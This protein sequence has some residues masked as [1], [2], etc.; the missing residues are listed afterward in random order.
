MNPATIK[1]SVREFAQPQQRRGHIDMF[2]GYAK[3]MQ[4]GTEIHSIIQAR[5]I[6]AIPNYQQEYSLGLEITK[7]DTAFNISGRCDGVII[8]DSETIIEEIKTTSNIQRLIETLKEIPDHPYIL[9]AKTYGFIY[10]KTTDITPK[11][12]LRLVSSIGLKEN[13][14]EV[15]FDI[16]EYEKWFFTRL[17]ILKNQIIGQYKSNERRKELAKNLKFPFPSNRSSQQDLI[18][19]I[20]NWLANPTHGLIQA[21]TG[22]GKTAG[23]MY[24]TLKNSLAKGAQLI[25]VTPK[26]SQH[27]LAKET[28]EKFQ[29]NNQPVRS[30]TI[31][32]KSKSCMLE[33]PLCSPDHCPYAKNY[34][35]KVSEHKIK[36]KMKSYPTLDLDD[37]KSLAE[38]Y[39]VCPF[40]LSLEAARD[41][42][43]VICDYNY[44]FSP[45][46]S[47]TDLYL[48]ENGESLGANLVIDEAHNLPSRATDYFSPELQTSFIEPLRE[49]LDLIPVDMQKKWKSIVNDALTCIKNQDP[50]N[51]QPRSLI[52][53]DTEGFIS[54]DTRIA[55]FTMQ[56]FD[57]ISEL[58]SNDPVIFLQRYW[59]D[60]CFSLGL[61]GEHSFATFRHL[62]NSKSV[63]ITCC[64]ASDHLRERLK[65]FSNVIAFSATLKPFEYYAQLSGF[66]DGKF[67]TAEFQSPF[68]KENRKILVIPQV[69]TLY[70]DREKNYPKIGEAINKLVSIKQGNYFVFFS[71][72]DFMEQTL[73]FINAQGYRLYKQERNIG[74]DEAQEVI[75]AL[76]G[77]SK[78][79]LVLAVQGGVFAEGVDYPGDTLIGA[80]VVG[81]ALPGFDFERE[82]LRQYYDQ[83]YT[84][85]FEYAYVYPGM[86]K[87]IQSAGRVIRSETDKGIIILL[88]ARFQNSQYT[89]VMPGFWFKDSVNE[90]ISNQ[91]TKDLEDFW[92]DQK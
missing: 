7:D 19:M 68:P 83:K 70:R 61:G 88:G 48:D 58:K 90:L 64:D 14:Y 91:I 72:F 26:N 29:E 85:G 31:N 47:F 23:V 1:I 12:Q 17:S 35:D 28:V 89:N 53:L 45:R 33:E 10:F 77:G 27:I 24:P 79:V 44:I 16:D 62:K 73:P 40:E 36:D 82:Q 60:F 9:Q 39:E 69:S 71:S 3:Q 67:T 18:N 25:Y 54:I 75:N 66:S 80:I 4:L 43:V 86:A 34:Y 52:S 20:D 38:T 55:A 46:I 6:K 50:N 87:V 59:G 42:D 32:A 30:L 81:P 57:Q 21:P 76:K 92:N 78:K 63:K 5:S 13:T 37:F 8:N 74:R 56:Y 84:K 15:D 22:L 49:N 2:S 51:H 11:V 41:V 65:C